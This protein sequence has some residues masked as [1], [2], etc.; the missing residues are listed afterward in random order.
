MQKIM[1]ANV[2]ETGEKSV[3]IKISPNMLSDTTENGKQKENSFTATDLILSLDAAMDFDKKNKE[4]NEVEQFTRKFET[5]CASLKE[6]RKDNYG[7]FWDYY[8]PYF[9][10]MKDKNF[11]KTYSY[12]AFASSDDPAI[13]Q[14]LKDHKSEADKFF[15]WSGSFEW[16]TN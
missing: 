8:V 7:F 16:K 13:S 6:T 10:E 4:K 11:I 9:I 12:I 1:K 3:T 15:E 2:E 5:V 14:W